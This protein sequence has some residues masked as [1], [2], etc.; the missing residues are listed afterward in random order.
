MSAKPDYGI[1]APGV[2]R[3][4]LIIGVALCI[5]NIFFT[6]VTIGG[7]KIV[8]SRTLFFPGAAFIIEGILMLL[9]SK[10]GKFR[11]RDKM[12]A[13]IQWHGDEKVLDVGTG[14]GLLLLGAA[15]HLS[16]GKATGIDIWS[17][18]DLSGNSME[19]T[20]RNA[21]LEGVKDK[22]ELKTEDASKM[23]FA[24]ETFDVVVSNLCIHNLE[25]RVARDA[26]CREIMRVLKPGGLAVISD[27]IKTGQYAKVFAES[28][29]R[30]ERTGPAFLATFPPLRI[31]TARKPA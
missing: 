13:R 5:L 7:L 15:K 10:F 2:I 22:V 26:A 11:H 6:S 8:F 30:V 29:A 1:D 9:Y 20:L 23:N 18:K 3:N 27:F 12:L 25:S 31:V 24:D 19:G 21:E 17:A 16:S 4:M 28:G 14:R